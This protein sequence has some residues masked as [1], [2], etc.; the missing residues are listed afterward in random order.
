MSGQDNNCILFFLKYPTIGQ[1]KTRLSAELNSQIAISLY[2]N[3]ILDILSTLQKLN[4]PFKIFFYPDVAQEK[5]T[6]WLGQQYSYL[7][8]CGEN[9]GERMK[10]AFLNTFNDNFSR[11]VIIG[12]DSP[13]LSADLLRQAFQVLES[14][15]AVI[16]PASDGGYYLLGFSK[17]VFLPEAFDNI[18][19]STDSVF[20]QTVNVLNQHRR[21]IYFLPQWYDVDTLDDLKS[22]LLR[23]KN[24]DFKQSKTYFY[25]TSNKLWS[26]SDV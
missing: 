8:Q 3:F 22:L 18:S 19:W 12:S 25:L 21:K 24:T 16:G 11:I 5:L 4:L 1:V 9:L 7:P 20:E 10:N 23:N 26:G 14:H 17:K 13:D 2:K 15:D 6:E